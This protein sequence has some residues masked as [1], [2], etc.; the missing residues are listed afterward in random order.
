MQILAS[1]VTKGNRLA[2]VGTDH[3][4]IPIALVLQKKIPSAVAMDVNEG[5]LKRARQHIQEQGL[6]TYIEVRLSDGLEKLQPNEADTVL[7]AG[8]G[9][10]LTVQILKGGSHCLSTVKELILQPQS[11]IFLVRGYLFQNG[12]RIL[13]EDIVLE[14]GKYYPIIKA[15]LGKEDPMESVTFAELYYGKV[16]IQ[17]SLPVLKDYLNLEL[18]KTKSLIEVLKQ[19]GQEHSV[20]MEELIQKQERICWTQ[21][22]MKSC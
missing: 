19:N 6:D 18:C 17:K 4:Y 9:G 3:G 21:Q 20:R 5:P 7:I 16:Q 11:E 8:M 22:K 15:V 13:E 10:A 1:K 14:D 12:Y 2:D